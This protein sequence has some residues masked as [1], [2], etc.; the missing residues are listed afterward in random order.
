MNNFIR[1]KMKTDRCT[2]KTA[3]AVDSPDNSKVLMTKLIAANEKRIVWDQR[4]QQKPRFNDSAESIEV[5]GILSSIRN[6]PESMLS[7]ST[8]QVLYFRILV[9]QIKIVM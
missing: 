1:N 9:F 8:H 5:N 2:H 6:E 4:N 3:T 7:F